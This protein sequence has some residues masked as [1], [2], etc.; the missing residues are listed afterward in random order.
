MKSKCAALMAV[1]ALS[2]AAAALAHHGQAAYYTTTTVTV[3]GVVTDFRFLNP[4][5]I[6]DIEV[7]DEQGTVQEWQGELTSP[8]RLVRS[9][10]NAHTL[11]S[12]DEITITGYRAKSGTNSLWVTRAVLSN[13]QELKLSGGN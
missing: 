13:G 12:G 6:L 10:W 7:K 5:V 2:S 4:H 11:K 8:N 3:K 1:I 9:G